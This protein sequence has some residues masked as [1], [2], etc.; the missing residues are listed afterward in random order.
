VTR[1]QQFSQFAPVERQFAFAHLLELAHDF[2][3]FPGIGKIAR[4]DLH[5][6]QHLRQLR[7][8]DDGNPKVGLLE[9]RHIDVGLAFERLSHLGKARRRGRFRKHLPAEER[10]QVAVLA[11]H[12]Y[13][14]VRQA[15]VAGVHVTAASGAAPL[16]GRIIAAR[17]RL[18]FIGAKSV[19][20]I[21]K[22]RARAGRTAA[23]RRGSVHLQL[24]QGVPGIDPRPLH[25]IEEFEIVRPH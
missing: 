5:H 19:D 11:D 12:G 16:L 22:I 2:Q 25:R 14:Y 6:P 7:A 15:Y 21:A 18:L 23:R 10:A 3:P 8:G 9:A 13:G 4:E 24:H 1:E 17:A 20:Q